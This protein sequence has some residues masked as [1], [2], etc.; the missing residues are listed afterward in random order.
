MIDRPGKQ[1]VVPHA[2][3]RRKQDSI[4]KGDRELKRMQLFPQ[5]ALDEWPEIG[6]YA[7]NIHTKA[8]SNKD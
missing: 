1:V 6:I 7:T 2:L 3:S 5:E 8:L 4:D